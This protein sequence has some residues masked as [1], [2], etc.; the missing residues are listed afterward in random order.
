MKREGK[1]GKEK[2]EKKKDYALEIIHKFNE[3]SSAMMKSMTKAAWGERKGLIQL[4]GVHNI[5]HLHR[6]SVKELRE[7]LNLEEKLMQ[8]S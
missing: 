7:A 1:K 2:K 6:K 5:I 3:C 8:W 4:Q